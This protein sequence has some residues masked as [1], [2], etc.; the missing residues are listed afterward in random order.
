M[1]LAL[2]VDGILNTGKN[3]KVVEQLKKA[4]TD[5]F[6][7]ADLGEVSLNLGMKVTRDYK[8]GALSISQVD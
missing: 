5:R 6:A 2:Y 7:M 4:L 3:E 8:Q 1:I